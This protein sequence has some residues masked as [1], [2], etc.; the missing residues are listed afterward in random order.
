MRD[1]FAEISGPKPPSMHLVLASGDGDGAIL[2]HN[3]VLDLLVPVSFLKKRRKHHTFKDTQQPF[4]REPVR[5]CTNIDSSKRGSVQHGV[6]SDDTS[7]LH[8]RYGI[9]TLVR[10]IGGVFSSRASSVVPVC[11]FL[12][13][14]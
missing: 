14:M 8:R 9:I 7:S 4:G 1:R 3:Q 13:L 6:G 12:P 5:T 11:V 2:L 10:L